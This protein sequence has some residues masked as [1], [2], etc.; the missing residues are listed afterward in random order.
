MVFGIWFVV[1]LVDTAEIVR[2]V[3]YGWKGQGTHSRNMSQPCQPL[4]PS[5]PSPVPFP[6][7]NQRLRETLL[8][9]L[10][11]WSMLLAFLGCLHHINIPHLGDLCWDGTTV[12]IYLQTPC[13]GAR[14]K[15]SKLSFYFREFSNTSST[16]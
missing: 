15:A 14:K 16:G 2:T 13:R 12:N 3:G 8:S 11:Y 10:S 6:S 5:L 9:F 1:Y 7:G 4:T